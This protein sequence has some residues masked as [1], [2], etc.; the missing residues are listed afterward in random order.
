MASFNIEDAAFVG[1]GLIARKPLAVIAW[2]AIWA[3]FLV[4]LTAPFAGI[5]AAF[6]TLNV[7]SPGHLDPG[8]AL[9]LVGALCAWAL[10]LWIGSLLLGAMVQSAVIRAVLKPQDSSLAYLR[11]GREE[12]FVL[13]VNFVKSLILVAIS[14]V[15]GAGLGI[16][17]AMLGGAGAGTLATAR[18]V[19]DLVILGVAA[20]VNL[21]FSLAAAMSFRERHF[22]LFEAWTLTRGMDGRLIGVLTIVI[23]MAAATW[24][25]TACVGLGGGILI[26]NG[27][28]HVTDL[29]NLLALEPGAWGPVVAPYVALAGLMS[30]VAGTLITPIALAPWVHI[31]QVLSATAEVEAEAG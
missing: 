31:Y 2:T 23:L 19:G 28:S 13:S 16:V 12:T 4:V 17:E 15:A 5:M 22:R 8:A 9:P 3:V 11:F 6:I 10:L 14:I 7:K 1:P 29:R 27:G 30:L 18:V 20:W 26:Q 25:V 21:R 24:L